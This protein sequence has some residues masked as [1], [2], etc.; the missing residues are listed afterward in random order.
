MEEEVVVRWRRRRRRIVF[1]ASIEVIV[2]ERVEGLF[3]LWEAFS[4]ESWIISIIVI[5]I[6][7]LRS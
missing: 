2:V 7:M 6:R 5:R 3:G 4:R 1:V